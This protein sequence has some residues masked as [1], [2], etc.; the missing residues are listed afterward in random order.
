MHARFILTAFFAVFYYLAYAQSSITDNRALFYDKRTATYLCCVPE[1]LFDDGSVS[2]FSCDTATIHFTFLPIVH[3]HGNFGME[4]SIG[5][6]DVIM[7]DTNL[8]EAQMSAKIK[9]RGATSNSETKHKHNYHIKF[10][11][12]K[13]KKQ[14]R[15]FFG[16]R[17]DNNWL[18]DAGQSD[19]SRI[20]N[21]AAQDLWN[22]FATKPYYSG[23]EEKAHS[24]TRGKMVEVFLNDEYL[25]IYGIME[26]VDR[27]QMK[28]KKYDEV[29]GTIHGQLWK[30]SGFT[31]THMWSYNNYD[32]ERENWGSFFTKYPDIDDVCPTDYALIYDLVRFVCEA[33]DEDF[34]AYIEQY[35]D[36]PVVIDYFLLINALAAV[37]NYSGK[38]IYWACYDRQTDKKLTLAVWDLDCTIGRYMSP[39]G[40][41]PYFLQ[42]D[43][44]DDYY[45]GNQLFYRLDAGNVN[46]FHDRCIKRWNEVRKT[47]FSDERFTDYYTCLMD[48]LSKSG[49]Y[50]REE[51]RWSGDSDI[52]GQ[53]LDFKAE[54]LFITN[55]IKVRMQTFDAKGFP[56]DAIR[57]V[58]CSDFGEGNTLYDLQGLRIE[59][60]T[61]PGLYIRNGKK[62]V[63]YR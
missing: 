44:H 28:L 56:T 29:T 61:H 54:R 1:T 12:D 11:D 14:N 35:I 62:F 24:A 43:T 48:M 49:A 55:W 50:D 36:M 5:T 15:S 34:A 41:D 20:R 21:R 22:D 53:T 16:L 58:W 26:N 25:G 40:M 13:G 60:P 6:V 59:N 45:W 51:E 47:Y 23:Q 30:G 27:M 52:Y 31:Y 63:I 46:G 18:L 10:L 19:L 7:P 9:W 17:S 3:L 2:R 57:N 33:S 38:N 8:D 42:P 39:Q 32:N 4:Y 37:D